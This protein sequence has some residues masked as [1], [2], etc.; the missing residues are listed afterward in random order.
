MKDYLEYFK[1]MR[2]EKKIYIV[3]NKLDLLINDSENRK[4][5]KKI[6]NDLEIDYVETSAL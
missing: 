4:I 2:H 1:A 6:A 5:A 3:G